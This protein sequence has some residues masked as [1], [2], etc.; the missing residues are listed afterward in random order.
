MGAIEHFS[1]D[2]WNEFKSEIIPDLFSDNIFREG[3]FLFRGHRSSE[4]QLISCY[5]RFKYKH[6]KFSN[7]I[8]IFKTECQSLD[9]EQKIIDNDK[10]LIAFAQHHGIPT[11]LLDWSN[12]PYIAS[13]FAFSDYISNDGDLV[14]NISIWVLNTECGIWSHDLGVEIIKIPHIG[15]IRIRNQNGCFTLSNT[16]F[17]CLEEYVDYLSSQCNGW[18][19]REYT[20]PSEEYLKAISDLD[21]MGI[22]WSRIFPGIEG[23][24]AS[25]FVKWRCQN[26]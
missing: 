8:D 11:R 20:I 4:W 12:S 10:Y 19:L 15:N 9:I 2:S 6:D 17:K 23:S 24:A 26:N 7:L 13:F 3:K 18:A 16:P 1:F 14:D 21:S 22:N 5:D 25:S